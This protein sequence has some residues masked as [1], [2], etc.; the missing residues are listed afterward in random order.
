MPTCP[1]SFLTAVASSCD[2]LKEK[3]RKGGTWGGELAS[4]A[5]RHTDAPLER[6]CN[7]QTY[8]HRLQMGE[9]RANLRRYDGH[10]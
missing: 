5:A 4:S 10:D 3:L 9:G 1:M 6:W 8:E 2:S 7:I